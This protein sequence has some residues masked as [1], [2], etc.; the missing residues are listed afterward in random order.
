NAEQV[1]RSDYDVDESQVR[2][3]FE[4]DRVLR[5]G[6]FFAAN[7]LYG[8]TFK[9]RKDI[10]VYQ[11]DVRVF[12]VFDADGSSLALF[13]GDF[14]SRPNKSGGAWTGSFVGQSKLLGT[15]PVVYNVENFTKP[16]AGQPALLTFSDVTTLFHEFGNALHALFST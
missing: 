15:K 12:E 1:R 7:K 13:Y 8:L 16:A 14:F 6:V 9:E 11:Q 4:I 10:P 2:P 3:Y 5:D